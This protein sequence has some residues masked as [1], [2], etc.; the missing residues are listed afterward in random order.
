MV[1]NT[2]IKETKEKI[3]T[4]LAKIIAENEGP[5]ASEGLA[6]LLRLIVNIVDKPT[7]TKFRSIK[8]TNAKIQ[9][10]VFTL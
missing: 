7:E 8:T 6:L 4:V 10:T 2:N 9:S 1:E 5:K 3:K